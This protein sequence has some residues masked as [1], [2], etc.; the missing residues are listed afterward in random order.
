MSN[1]LKDQ[2]VAMNMDSYFQGQIF[3][4]ETMI[5]TLESNLEI[6]KQQRDARINE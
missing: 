1:E 5:R 6:V 3:I 4:L 2:L